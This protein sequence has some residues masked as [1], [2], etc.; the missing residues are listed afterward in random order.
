M[1]VPSVRAGQRQAVRWT[2]T[3]EDQHR[4]DGVR[5]GQFA[6]TRRQENGSIQTMDTRRH[7]LKPTDSN[8]DRGSTLSHLQTHTH[9]HTHTLFLS[10]SLH[11]LK[12][13]R[14]STPHHL[15]RQTID[16]RQDQDSGL[17]PPLSREKKLIFLT[18]WP[19]IK[20]LSLLM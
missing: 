10:V 3:R 1:D 12:I 20:N 13:R 9:T 18:Q 7:K 16:T 15:C 6:K 8:K 17:K 11:S 14:K 5:D 2:L 4:G 19:T